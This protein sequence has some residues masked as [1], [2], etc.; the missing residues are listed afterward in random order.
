MAPK[1]FPC[2]DTQESTHQ[3][4]PIQYCKIS[5]TIEPQTI[6]TNDATTNGTDDPT[7]ENNTRVRLIISL[8]IIGAVIVCVVVIVVIISILI[9]IVRKC[10][11]RPPVSQA[12]GN[13]DPEEANGT[14][15]MIVITP[16]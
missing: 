7:H 12:P 8:S 15:S 5:T 10:R 16:L 1:I 4:L 6:T 2:A 9:I 13:G 3:L 11:S 14:H